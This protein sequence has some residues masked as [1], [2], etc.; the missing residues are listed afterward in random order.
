MLLYILGCFVAAV[1]VTWLAVKAA[2]PVN[3]WFDRREA[4]TIV[5]GADY[6][7]T[8]TVK[9]A[10]P[11]QPAEIKSWKVKVADVACGYVKYFHYRGDGTLVE[12]PFEVAPIYKFKMLFD[13]EEAQ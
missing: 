8:Y 4:A 10:N 2:R 1:I 6:R 3:D 7:A 9:A 11:W 12:Y 13:L 5:V